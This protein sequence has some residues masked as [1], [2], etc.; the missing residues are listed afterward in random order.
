[1]TSIRDIFLRNSLTTFIPFNASKYI[2]VISPD[3]LNDDNREQFESAFSPEYILL[4]KDIRPFVINSL[5]EEECLNLSNRLGIERKENQDI[6]DAVNDCL[7][8]GTYEQ[9]KVLFQELHADLSILDDYFV[10]F[11]KKNKTWS[12][13]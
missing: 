3:I 6:W 2:E 9:F 8:R 1:M 4:N 10:K 13:R 12:Q 5:R 11:S 7:N